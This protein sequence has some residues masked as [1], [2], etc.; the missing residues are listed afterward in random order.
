[1]YILYVILGVLLMGFG[2]GW[3]ILY[4]GF[5]IY[6][7]YIEFFPHWLVLGLAPLAGGYFLMRHGLRL[8]RENRAQPSSGDKP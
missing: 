5:E 6:E 2:G 1:M 4:L 7:A 8:G 3:T